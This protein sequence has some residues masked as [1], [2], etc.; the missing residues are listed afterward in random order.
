ME[1]IPELIKFV[2]RLV[3]S[4]AD[5]ITLHPRTAEQKRRGTADWSQITELKKSISIPVIGNGD[6][7][8]VDDVLEMLKTTSADKV[9]VTKTVSRDTDTV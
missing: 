8:I 3:D 2:Q 4:G 5:W 9:T 1:T 7:Q 6:I